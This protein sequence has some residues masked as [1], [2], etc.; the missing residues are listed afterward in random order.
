MHKNKYLLPICIFLTLLLSSC[1]V[2]KYVPEGESLLD[3]VNITTD[4]KD[5]KDTD[6]S[7]YL[8]QQPNLK[9]T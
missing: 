1:N 3:K 6:F 2:T 9:S 5:L 7:I 4:E 8:R